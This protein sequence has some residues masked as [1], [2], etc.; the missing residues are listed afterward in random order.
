MWHPKPSLSQFQARVP[1]IPCGV[2]THHVVNRL[3][4]TDEALR[5]LKEEMVFQEPRAQKQY[6]R[7]EASL[8]HPYLR[9]D[10]KWGFVIVRIVYGPSSDVPWAQLLELFRANV[11]ETLRLE[12]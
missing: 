2:P 12:N 4:E 10:T 8:P 5:K 6:H 9:P 11:S 3:S 7:T 1:H